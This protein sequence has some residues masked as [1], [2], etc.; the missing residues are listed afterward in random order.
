MATIYTNQVPA[1]LAEQDTVRYTLG[2]VFTS[3]VAGQVTA[4][5]YYKGNS[6]TA[7]NNQ[8]ITVGLYTATGTLLGSG[9]RTFLSTDPQGWV[10]V[11]LTTPVDI[12]AGTVYVASYE[13]GATTNYVDTPGGF[14]SAGIDNPPLHALQDSTSQHNGVFHQGNTL[15]FPTSTFQG[16]DYFV[17][18]EFTAASAGPSHGTVSGTATW[19]G[20]VAGT[21][22][23]AGSATGHIAWLGTVTGHAPAPD[24]IPSGSTTGGLTW[25]GAVAGSNGTRARRN[26]TITIGPASAGWATASASGSWSSTS[27]NAGGWTTDKP[28]T[29]WTTGPVYS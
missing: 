12:T 15:T 2:T 11:P 17:D 28:A 26:I 29:G 7:W 27:A 22:R 10:S 24:A 5:R 20:A 25:T 13:T 9:T 6:T 1:S 4:I 3:D 23:R 21:T 8:T 19:T 18:V 14:T 16:A